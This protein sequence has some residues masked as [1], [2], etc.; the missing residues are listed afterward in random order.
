MS[1]SSYPNNSCLIENSFCMKTLSN[2]VKFCMCFA[3]QYLLNIV[4]FICLSQLLYFH[5][6]FLAVSRVRFYTLSLLI[7]SAA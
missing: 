2:L 3:N 7:G 4:L 6:T 1:T 5:F